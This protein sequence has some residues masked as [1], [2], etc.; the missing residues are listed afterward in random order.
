MH[1]LGLRRAVPGTVL[2]AGSRQAG[3]PPDEGGNQPDEG[4]NR[5]AIGPLTSLTRE[6]ISMHS[7]RFEL[8]LSDVPRAH[9]PPRLRVNA[10]CAGRAASPDEGGNQSDEV[11]NQPDEGYNQR[12][13]SSHT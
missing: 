1:H 4:G 2:D 11:D 12:W 13:R 8:V 10:A 9:H 5:K 7:H 6:A 3:I